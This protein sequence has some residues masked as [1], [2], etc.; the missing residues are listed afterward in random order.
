VNSKRSIFR[1]STKIAGRKEA[2]ARE[3]RRVLHLEH[4]M[5]WIPAG[6]VSSAQDDSLVG[7]VTYNVSDVPAQSSPLGSGLPL[8]FYVS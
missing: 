1:D 3:R 4:E 6:S 8:G 7:Q 2:R 5:A